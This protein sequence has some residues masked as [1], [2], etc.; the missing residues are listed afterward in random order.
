MARFRTVRAVVLGSCLVALSAIV[1][2][3]EDA[4]RSPHPVSE[5]GTYSFTFEN[6][7]FAGD[8]KD[9]A[10]DVRIDDITPPERASGL[11]R[12]R[13]AQSGLAHRRQGLALRGREVE[14]THTHVFRSPEFQAQDGF[15]EFGS[16]NL[17]FKF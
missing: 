17:R 1:A 14:L 4:P 2:G 12:T 3:A 15:T 8:D 10:N 7:T 6:G 9:Y 11:G 16:H 5:G 13:A